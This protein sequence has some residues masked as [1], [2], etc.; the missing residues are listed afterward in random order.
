M[1]TLAKKEEKK[2]EKE[3]P[4]SEKL[5]KSR[6][7]LL[8]KAVDEKMM[9]SVLA[10]LMI[11]ESDN[12]DPITIY[13]NSP[14]G[15]A[16]VG[17]AIY[18]MFKFVD[19]PII[20]VCS[21][22]CASAAILIFLGGEKGHRYSL[23]NSRF[24]IHQP[25]TQAQGTAS[26]LQITAQEII[27]LRGRYNEIVGNEVGCAPEKVT[28]DSVRDFWLSPQEAKKYGLVSKIVKNKSEISYKI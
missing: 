3:V 7:I 19:S 6:T 2:E 13:I 9:E 17:F 22:I 16:D 25:S 11:M 18:D 14:G 4:Y 28:E 15:A 20:T 21:G 8:S 27:K 23:P 10:Q 1:I 24:L 12:S 5:I 26:D